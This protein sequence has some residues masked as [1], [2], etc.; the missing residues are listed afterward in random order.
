MK[1]CM[2]Y[3]LAARY[4]LLGQR[5]KKNFSALPLYRVV[6]RKYAAVINNS[7]INRISVA[8][9]LELSKEL[10]TNVLHTDCLIVVTF[11]YCIAV[12]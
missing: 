1:E 4:S 8:V 3:P 12:M 9:P 2:S 7:Y 11:Y 10:F 5:T 6:V